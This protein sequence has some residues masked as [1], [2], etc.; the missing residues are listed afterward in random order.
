[1]FSKYNEEMLT[2]CSVENLETGTIL[3][4]KWSFIIETLGLQWSNWHGCNF[5]VLQR[6]FYE[7]H[8]LK[9]ENATSIWLIFWANGKRMID[10]NFL[11]YNKHTCIMMCQKMKKRIDVV[12]VE[13]ILLKRLRAQAPQFDN[14]Y[15][16]SGKCLYPHR[17]IED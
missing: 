2:F 8:R 11:H 9:G 12:L 1:M 13:V 4:E 15:S 5:L 17:F 14:S 7:C 16:N 6:Q 10:F 3:F